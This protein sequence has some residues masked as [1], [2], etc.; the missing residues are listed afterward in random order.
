MHLCLE[1]HAVLFE[2]ELPLLY[3]IHIPLPQGFR[4]SWI[5]H[6]TRLVLHFVG[7]ELAFQLSSFRKCDNKWLI[8][9]AP[10]YHFATSCL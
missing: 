5:C 2:A 7:Q 6:C 3:H 9:W 10:Q 1:Y 8:V 4:L